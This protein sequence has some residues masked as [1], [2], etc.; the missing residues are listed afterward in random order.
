MDYC[1]DQGWHVVDHPPFSPDLNPIENLWFLI[2]WRVHK[3]HRPTNRTELRAAVYNVWAE[4][5]DEEIRP[6]FSNMPERIEAVI[7]AEGGR[8]SY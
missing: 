5:T 2:D 3:Y 1:I 6:F 8:T 4:L 7:A